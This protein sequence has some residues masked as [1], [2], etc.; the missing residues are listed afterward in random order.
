M[1]DCVAEEMTKGGEKEKPH[2]FFLFPFFPS[3][4]K[5]SFLSP[6]SEEA[7]AKAEGKQ[8]G[9]EGSSST[10]AAKVQREETVKLVQKAIQV[11]L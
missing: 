4:F 2:M 3:R 10:P 11:G 8:A 1:C 9:E 7:K 5:Y 6:S